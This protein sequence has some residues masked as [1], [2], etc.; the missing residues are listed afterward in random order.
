MSDLC[1]NNCH[2]E[3]GAVFSFDWRKTLAEAHGEIQNLYGDAALIEK[4]CALSG[5]VVSNTGTLMFM[6]VGMK[7]DHKLSKSLNGGHCSMRSMSGAKRTCL[8]I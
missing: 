5:S 7:E 2:S 4:T 3:E 6:I 1:P 8:R